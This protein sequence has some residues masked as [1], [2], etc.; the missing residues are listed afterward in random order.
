MDAQNASATT[1][2][3][4]EFPSGT[5]TDESLIVVCSDDGIIRNA[6]PELAKGMSYECRAGNIAIFPNETDRSKRTVEYDPDQVIVIRPHETVVVKTYESFRVPHD[7][8]IRFWLK[9]S[10]FTHGLAPVHTVA[11]PGFPGADPE[12]PGHMGIVLHNMS[13]RYVKIKPGE[14]LAKAEVVKL[15]AKV[16]RPYSG[17]HGFATGVWP[18]SD[19]YHCSTELLKSR[20]IQPTSKSEVARAYGLGVDLMRKRIAVLQFAISI[21]SGVVF[22]MDLALLLHSK[23]SDLKTRAALLARY[24]LHSLQGY[25]LERY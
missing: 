20:K 21:L 12:A 15:T 9:G 4:E 2:T 25:C 1:P 19:K 10:L 17:Q 3:W 14:G 8:Y 5:L 24:S 11:D 6:N 22:F 16:R 18:D 13:N 7:C 23:R